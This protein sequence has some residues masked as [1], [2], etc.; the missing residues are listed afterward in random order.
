[1]DGAIAAAL[2]MFGDAGRPDFVSSHLI[3]SFIIINIFTFLVVALQFTKHLHE[4]LQEPY[5][6]LMA[7]VFLNEETE[8]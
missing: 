7:S 2:L 4:F 1:M 5:E 3:I 8:A 6:F